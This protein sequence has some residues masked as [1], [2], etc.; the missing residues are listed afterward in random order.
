DGGEADLSVPDLSSNTLA[1][2]EPCILATQCVSGF[3]VDGVCCNSDC[4]GQCQACDIT[5]G[6]GVGTCQ[7][8]SSGSPHG[9]RTACTGSGVCQGSCDGSSATACVYPTGQCSPQS[10]TGST[11]KLAAFCSGGTCPTPLTQDCAPTTCNSAGT[12]CIG[13]CV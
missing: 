5:G 4:S 13:S 6:S 7:T 3:C 12:G 8:V 9:T 1:Q 2:G 11:L 10:C